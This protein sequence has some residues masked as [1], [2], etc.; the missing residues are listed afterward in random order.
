MLVLNISSDYATIHRLVACS[1]NHLQYRHNL[2]LCMCQ[3]QCLERGTF[4]E[5]CTDE[6]VLW[7]I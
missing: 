5:S 7:I 6:G 3:Y 1:R 4:D 2:L